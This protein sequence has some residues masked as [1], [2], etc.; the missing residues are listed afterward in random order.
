MTWTEPRLVP[1]RPPGLA[2][3]RVV[4]SRVGLRCPFAP[5]CLGNGF[6]PVLPRE[7]N[8]LGASNTRVFEVARS[9]SRYDE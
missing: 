8:A 6:G 7:V 2:S 1:R 3:R 5:L 9:V 4:W